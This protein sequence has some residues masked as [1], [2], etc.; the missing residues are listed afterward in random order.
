MTDIPLTAIERSLADGEYHN[1]ED[2]GGTNPLY[3]AEAAIALLLAEIRRLK[4]LVEKAEKFGAHYTVTDLGP[5]PEK[6]SDV[7]ITRLEVI[8]ENGRMLTIRPAQLELSFQDGGRTLK[9][10]VTRTKDTHIVM[11]S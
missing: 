1:R 9:V 6:S 4:P 3:C 10:F 7:A 8:G 2:W 5:R 11:R